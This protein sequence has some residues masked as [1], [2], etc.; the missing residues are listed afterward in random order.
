MVL[1][2]F[3]RDIC[4]LMAQARRVRGGYSTEEVST[5]IFAGLPPDAGEL[6]RLGEKHCASTPGVCTV[7]GRRSGPGPPDLGQEGQ[8]EPL[9]HHQDPLGLPHPSRDNPDVVRPGRQVPNVKP[10]PVLSGAV[11]P[12]HDP[13]HRPA[14]HVEKGQ[15]HR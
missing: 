14:L 13:V 7:P 4:R 3:Q 15:P 11:S 6:S 8:E 10:H 1:A 5:L 9:P 2:S 12:V